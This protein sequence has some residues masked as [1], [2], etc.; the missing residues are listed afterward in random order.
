[1]STDITLNESVTVVTVSNDQGPQGPTGSTGPTG[2]TGEIGIV[3]SNTAPSNHGQLWADTSTTSAQVV[4]FD[5]GT[6]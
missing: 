1:M 4:V 2:A 6:A 3:I 5:G